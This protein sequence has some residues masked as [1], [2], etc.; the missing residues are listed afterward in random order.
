MSLEQGTILKSGVLVNTL[1]MGEGTTIDIG[2][3]QLED[4]V[5]GRACEILA[6]RTTNRMELLVGDRARIIVDQVHAR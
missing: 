5:I 1:V 3:A 4:S 2:E 6:R